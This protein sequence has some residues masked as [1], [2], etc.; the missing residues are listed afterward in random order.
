MLAPRLVFI[1]SARIRIASLSHRQPYIKSASKL[2][3][4]PMLSCSFFVCGHACLAGS[5]EKQAGRKQV[6][7]FSRSG[8]ASE[9]KTERQSR[10]DSVP[11]ATQSDVVVVIVVPRRIV[12][13]MWLLFWGKS[14]SKRQNPGR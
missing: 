11:S 1:S 4:N 5:K 13:K 9:A 3:P 2:S 10:Y 7:D 12:K 6:A 14:S 8:A